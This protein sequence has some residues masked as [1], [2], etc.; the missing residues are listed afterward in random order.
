MIT[1]ALMTPGTLVSDFYRYWIYYTEI[2]AVVIGIIFISSN[3]YF[4]SSEGHK[5]Y[6]Q[7]FHDSLGIALAYFL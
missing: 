2:T 7:S 5:E 1:F 3:S 6:C 4:E